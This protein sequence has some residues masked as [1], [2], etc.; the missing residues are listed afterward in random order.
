M[1]HLDL[2]SN[3]LNGIVPNDIGMDHEEMIVFDISGKHIHIHCN[4]ILHYK[5]LFLPIALFSNAG[6]KVTGPI[7]ESFSNMFNLEKLSLSNN[8]LTSTIPSSIG[9]ARSVHSLYLGK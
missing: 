6:N 5:Y 9:A 4:N 1:Q 8:K 2:S 7:P 3:R